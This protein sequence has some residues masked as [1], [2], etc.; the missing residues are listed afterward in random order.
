MA[1][2]LPG[3]RCEPTA[4]TLPNGHSITLP[5]GYVFVV[6]LVQLSE[7]TRE[8]SFRSRWRLT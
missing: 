2:E 1:V 8:V 7:L 4:L 5:S 3:R 6:I